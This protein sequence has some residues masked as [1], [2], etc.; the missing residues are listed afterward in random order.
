MLAR[1]RQLPG[2]PARR[3]VLIELLILEALAAQGMKDFPAA[4]SHLGE[5][6]Q[7]AAPGR[8]IRLFLDQGAP[9]GMLLQ[10]LLLA[11]DGDAFA[12]ELL[13]A[14]RIAPASASLALPEP[15]T[16]KEEK[17]AE[18]LARDWS[19]QQIADALFISLNTVKTHVKSIYRK[20]GV[21]SRQEAAERLRQSALS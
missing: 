12:R 16:P 20:L 18:C 6:L 13:A 8:F 9:L 10:R 15:L 5:A 1:L 14:F 4:L 2:L 3:S 7:L 21:S 17:I 19:N 11:G